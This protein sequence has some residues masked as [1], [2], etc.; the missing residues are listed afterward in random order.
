MMYSLSLL[1]GEREA[2]T[3]H[4]YLN[5]WQKNKNEEKQ[6]NWNLDGKCS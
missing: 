4:K 3:I 2:I 6:R 5:T 1:L